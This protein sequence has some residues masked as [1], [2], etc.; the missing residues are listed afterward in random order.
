[1]ETY[2]IL[3]SQGRYS[4]AND[5][6]SDQEGIYGYFPDFLNAIENRIYNLQ[7][8][9]LTLVPKQPFVCSDT[10]PAADNEIIWI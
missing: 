1:M 8:Y 4:D 7:E 2:D 10:E 6:I 9:L 3:I 5:F